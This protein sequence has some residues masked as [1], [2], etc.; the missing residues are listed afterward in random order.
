MRKQPKAYLRY[1]VSPEGPIRVGF[2]SY[3]RLLTE[4]FDGNDKRFVDEADLIIL[5]SPHYR[6]YAP[7]SE[8]EFRRQIFVIAGKQYRLDN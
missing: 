2:N 6:R 3:S 7:V 5:L 1:F 4:R 8:N